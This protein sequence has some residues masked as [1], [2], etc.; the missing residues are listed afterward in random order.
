MEV[1][2]RT[3]PSSSTTSCCGSMATMRG[4]ELLPRTNLGGSRQA[5]SENA[6]SWQA[7]V[8]DLRHGSAVLGLILAAKVCGEDEAGRFSIHEHAI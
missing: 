1:D 8:L 7:G 2:Q 6:G 4:G 5:G 3:C